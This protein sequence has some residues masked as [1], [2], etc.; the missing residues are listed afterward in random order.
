MGIKYKEHA[1]LNKA[2][3]EQKNSQQTKKNERD[4]REVPMRRACARTPGPRS[5]LLLEQS[6]QLTPNPLYGLAPAWRLLHVSRRSILDLAFQETLLHV[7]LLPY[8]H[9]ASLRRQAALRKAAAL[10]CRPGRPQTAG[11]SR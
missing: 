9:L 11:G 4:E 10:T 6:I 7:G 5:Y 8:G 2:S 3:I 1:H